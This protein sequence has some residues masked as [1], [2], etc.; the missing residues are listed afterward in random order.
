MPLSSRIALIKTG[1]KVGGQVLPY[2][3]VTR[4]RPGED[5]SSRQQRIYG[6]ENNR[7]FRDLVGALPEDAEALFRPTVIRS[8]AD[9]TRYPSARG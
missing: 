3:S 1:I 6:F 4:P 2:A 7:T 5:P 9:R 8:A